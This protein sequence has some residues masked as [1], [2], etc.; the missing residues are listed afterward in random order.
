MQL[1]PRNGVR[2]AEVAFTVEEDYHGQGIA[3][4]LLG[5]LIAIARARDL[6]ALEA[7]VLAGN[8]SMFRVFERTGLPIHTRHDGTSVHLRIAL[9]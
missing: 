5:H 7:E 8:R 2:S 6:D 3:G 9:R 1:A 4:H